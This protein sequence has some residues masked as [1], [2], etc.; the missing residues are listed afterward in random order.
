[1]LAGGVTC[2]HSNDNLLALGKGYMLVG[3]VVIGLDEGRGDYVGESP[4][5][6]ETKEPAKCFVQVASKYLTFA[7]GRV[8]GSKD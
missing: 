8:G 5:E 2:G 6:H 4:T 1:M 7:V 3:K